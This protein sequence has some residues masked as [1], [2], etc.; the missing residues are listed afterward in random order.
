MATRSVRCPDCRGTEFPGWKRGIRCE[1][2]D[3]S[4]EIDEPITPVAQAAEAVAYL[5][6]VRFQGQGKAQTYASIVDHERHDDHTDEAWATR[7]VVPLCSLADAQAA[8][9]ALRAQVAELEER[10]A[11]ALALCREAQDIAFAE[12]EQHRAQVAERD[13]V[14]AASRESNDRVGSWLSAAL[15]DPK[16]CEEMKADIRAWMEA[17][18]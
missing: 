13:R 15:D 18:K 6:T 4:A 11:F 1:R 12:R 10:A 16:V 2:C 7:Q 14:I 5:I 9:D 3:G 17:T 8:I